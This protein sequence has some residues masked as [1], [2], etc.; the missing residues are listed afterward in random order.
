MV[1]DILDSVLVFKFY[2]SFPKA[3]YSFPICN[4]HFGN[5]FMLRTKQSDLIHK[6]AIWL[7]N[8]KKYGSQVYSSK[9]MALVLPCLVSIT[10]DQQTKWGPPG[11]PAPRTKILKDE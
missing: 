8:S 6:L 9:Y 5:N 2:F 10:L 11:F 7:K 3:I 1:I 4:G